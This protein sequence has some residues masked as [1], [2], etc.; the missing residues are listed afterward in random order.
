[1]THISLRQ[2]LDRSLRSGFLMAKD[3]TGF[4]MAYNS[5]HQGMSTPL[6]AGFLMTISLSGKT[7]HTITVSVFDDLYLSPPRL[8]TPS[9]AGFLTYISLRQDWTQYYRV[10]DGQGLD[11][12]F[13]G[14]WQRTGHTSTARVLVAYSA[15]RGELCCRAELCKLMTCPGPDT[16]SVSSL[17]T[18]C[19]N[20]R[21]ILTSSL[22]V[23]LYAMG[24]Q[25]KRR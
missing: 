20:V 22:S 25:S 1:M 23:D 13:D 11:R 17:Q 18:N 3:W 24:N 8:D 19:Y 4:L 14:Q 10:S 6:R 9:R 12:V 2:R 15:V 21:R 16:L 5:V 7:G